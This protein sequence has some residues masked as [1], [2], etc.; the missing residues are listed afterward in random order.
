MYQLSLKK[1][2]TSIV[3]A[4]GIASVTQVNAAT[5]LYEMDDS[6]VTTNEAGQITSFS[7]AYDDLSEQLSFTSTIQRANGNLANG[8]WLVLSDGPYPQSNTAEYA[9]FYGDSTTRNLTAYVFDDYYM[10]YSWNTP[11][12][13]ILSYEDGL[14][15]NSAIND[16][17]T[18]HFSID[19]SYI[20]NFF[21]TD[22]WEGAS[23]SENIG[24]WYQPLVFSN[25]PRYNSDG[26]LDSFP[27]DISGWYDKSGLSTTK[28]LPDI[29]TVP[30]PATAW[31]VFV[32]LIGF[33]GANRRRI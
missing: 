30:T 31:L 26:S 10:G 4:V 28:I 27:F 6:A 9:I 18:F 21:D 33:A 24:I 13:F 11:G 7:T 5:Y 23:F 14:D 3:F 29:G 22:D 12:E 8:F 32:G 19:V 25:D 20:N 15:V 17:V 2:F 1:S 16:E